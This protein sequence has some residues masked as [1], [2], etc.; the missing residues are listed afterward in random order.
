MLNTYISI[1]TIE[2]EALVVNHQKQ[3]AFVTVICDFM[4]G[5][6]RLALVVIVHVTCMKTTKLWHCSEKSRSWMDFK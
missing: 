6:S 5:L 3:M 2:K 1:A 4:D